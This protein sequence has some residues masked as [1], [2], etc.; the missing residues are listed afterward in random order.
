[1]WH[2]L[3]QL[4][5]F[6]TILR[7]LWDNIDTN[8]KFWDNW[9]QN[10]QIVSSCSSPNDHDDGLATNSADGPEHNHVLNIQQA[11]ILEKYLPKQ[12]S[13]TEIKKDVVHITIL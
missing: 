2:N 10:F 6:G 12:L 13:E 11:E 8:R 4:N 9:L 7:H 3:G 1:M 5:I